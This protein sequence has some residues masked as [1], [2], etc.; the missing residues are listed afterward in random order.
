[1]VVGTLGSSTILISVMAS[2]PSVSEDAGGQ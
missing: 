1:M 2:M